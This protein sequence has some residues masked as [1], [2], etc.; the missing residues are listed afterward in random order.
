MQCVTSVTYTVRINGVPRGVIK[1]SWGLRQGDPL[2]PYLF[3]LC[4]E[5]LSALINKAVQ[6]KSIH[7]VAASAKGP[8]ISHL[9]FADDSLI[10]GKATTMECGEILRV[11]QVYEELSEQQLNRTKTSIFFSRNTD[12]T[13]KEAIR[14]SFGAQIIKPHES[15]LGLLSLVGRSKR[16]T[17]AQLKERVSNKLAGWKEML[18]SSAGK[19]ILIKAVAQAVPTYTMSCFRLPDALCDELTGLVRQ[20]WWG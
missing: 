3:L 2:L 19:E 16:N 15:Y 9:F 1:P 7:G 11:L 20:F 14:A 13:T 4:V 18:L 12:H 5:G 10:F 17:F 8:K 6:N